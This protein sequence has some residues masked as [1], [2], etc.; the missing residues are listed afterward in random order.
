ME[1]HL[2]GHL[3]GD[4]SQAPHLTE[5]ETEAQ[6]DHDLCPKLFVEFC[7]ASLSFFMFSPQRKLKAPCF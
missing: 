5:G 3:K 7:G 4:L 2:Q 6:R 1:S